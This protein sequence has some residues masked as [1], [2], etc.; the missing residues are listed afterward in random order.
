MI[1]VN[2]ANIEV[3]FVR[4]RINPNF[5]WIPHDAFSAFNPLLV[6]LSEARVAFVT[7]AGAH[8]PGQRPFD[9]KAA[10]GDPS[11]REFPTITPLDDLILTHR[12]YNTSHASMDKNVVLPLDHLRA[13]LEVGRIGSL[14]ANVYSTMGFVSD[15]EPLVNETGPAIAERL[16]LDDVDLVLM[17]PT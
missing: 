8:L 9:L 5:A 17:A 2:F 4:E 15:V 14:S 7:T 1:G 16:R 3:D 11:Y 6:P 12:G 13:A 10:E